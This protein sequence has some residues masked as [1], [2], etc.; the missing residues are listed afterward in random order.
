MQVC[1]LPGCTAQQWGKHPV[2]PG[3]AAAPPAAAQ[4]TPA[5]MQQP[6]HGIAPAQIMHVE[7]KSAMMMYVL[8]GPQHAC[9]N[10]AGSESSATGTLC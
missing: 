8:G 5:E 2:L 1:K 6:L 3:I 7:E 10:A 4:P 9:R